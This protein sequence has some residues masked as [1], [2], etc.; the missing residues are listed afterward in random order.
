MGAS[1]TRLPVECRVWKW[2]CV[3]ACVPVPALCA[4][5]PP[6]TPQLTHKP[7]PGSST[8]SQL[9]GAAAQA[10]NLTYSSSNSPLL[11]FFLFLSI[12]F[13]Y[14]FSIPFLTS[15]VGPVALSFRAA[16]HLQCTVRVGRLLMFSKHHIRSSRSMS[17]SLTRVVGGQKM[18]Q[19]FIGLSRH[20]PLLHS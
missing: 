2:G 13:F 18:K 14:S 4:C 7:V 8:A 20:P 19:L 12:S 15:A 17:S 1:G 5:S 10:P 16:Y 6:T 9:W 11:F 3:C